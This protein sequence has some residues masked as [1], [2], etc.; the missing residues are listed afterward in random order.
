MCGYATVLREA[1][2]C[3]AELWH[4]HLVELLLLSPAVL[5]QTLFPRCRKE[6]RLWM[7]SLAGSSITREVSGVRTGIARPS[8]GCC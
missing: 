1:S 7:W 5:W 3:Q 8:Q 6:S 2:L 4:C